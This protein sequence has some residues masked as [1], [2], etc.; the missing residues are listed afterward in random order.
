MITELN[1]SWEGKSSEVRA[2]YDL[3]SFVWNVDAGSWE[4]IGFPVP[5]SRIMGIN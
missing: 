5:R 3:S 2:A 4:S 1:L